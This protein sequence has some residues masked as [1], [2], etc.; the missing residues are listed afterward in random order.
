[1]IA[2]PIR[3]NAP[4]STQQARFGRF[5]VRLLLRHPTSELQRDISEAAP[6]EDDVRSV[7][8]SLVHAEIERADR[9]GKADLAI[10]VPAD[11]C[12]RIDTFQCGQMRK[13]QRSRD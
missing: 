6:A 5:D 1:M 4:L 8:H 11:W 13:H 12:I 7:E 2:R 9:A 10:D 3:M